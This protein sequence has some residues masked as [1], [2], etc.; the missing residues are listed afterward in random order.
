MQGHDF[1]RIGRESVDEI[2]AN[3]PHATVFTHPDVLDR[4]F[5]QVHWWGA[6]KRGRL[7]AAWPVPLDEGGCPTSSGWFYFMGPIWCDDAF[8]PL[9]HRSL[10]STI[11]VYTGLIDAIASEYGS[12]VASLPPPQT[13]VRAFTWWRYDE[14]APIRV[15]P[16]YSARLDALTSRPWEDIMADMR[17]L[18]RRELRRVE[19]V[20]TL[21]WSQGLTESELVEL[22]RVR[23]PGS[24]EGL[25]ANARRLLSLVDAGFGFTS[26]AREENGEAVAVIVA[27]CDE[28]M[29]NVVINSVADTWRGAGASV[30]NMARTLAHARDLG[31]DKFDFNGANSPSRGDDKHSYGASPVLYFDISFNET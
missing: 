12:F 23:V 4:F 29:A 31:L 26:V 1:G 2:W 21:D 16:R 18:R 17:Q 10:S 14:G 30:H 27:L 13:D 5:D 3:S 15:E 25:L 22:Y 19:A 11:P 8:P 7:V 9:A 20:R 28:S 6:I 24:R